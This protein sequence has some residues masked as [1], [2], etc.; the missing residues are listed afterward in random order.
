MLTFGSPPAPAP[1]GG[2]PDPI[3]PAGDIT[4]GEKL[5]EVSH[6][7][8][9]SGT[10]SR[11]QDRQ[12]SNAEAKRAISRN[13]LEAFQAAR[14]QQEFLDTSLIPEF[15]SVHATGLAVTRTAACRNDNITEAANSVA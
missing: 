2:L 11:A 12:L 9:L 1:S 7:S 13:L 14:S 5:L 4:F 15:E 6:A 10:L 3:S 8:W